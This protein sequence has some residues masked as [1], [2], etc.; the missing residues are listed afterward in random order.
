[1]CR[2]SRREFN[3][4]AITSGL[5]ATYSYAQP[6]PAAEQSSKLPL[7]ELSA[8]AKQRK[9][10]LRTTLRFYYN[11]PPSVS[12]FTP[13]EILHY[14]I[15][16]GVD[17]QVRTGDQQANAIGWLCWNYPAR[18]QRLF[19]RT[20]TGNGLVVN[21][22]PGVEGH[23]GQ[24]LALLAMS[25]VRRDFVIKVNGSEFA[26]NDLVEHEKLACD[27][28]TELTFQLLGLA[29]YLNAETVWQS[30]TGKEFT[31]ESLLKSELSQ[32]VNGAACGGSH[33]L[34]GISYALNRRNHREE[35]MTSVWLR[36]KKYIEDYIRYVLQLQN[37]D[38]SFSS[39]WFQSRGVT[40]DL[41][42]KLYT[43]GHVLEWLV[44]SVSNEQLL[45]DQVSSAVDYLSSTLHSQRHSG[46][47][48]GTVG[49]ALRALT[50]Y[51]ERVFGAKPGMRTELYGNSTMK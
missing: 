39:N 10:H 34:M 19:S 36:A 51:D 26:V 29:H 46:L 28:S 16:F 3:I 14:A 23:E 2:Y 8:A 9:K 31:I 1:M 11:N 20:A 12:Q 6:P 37:P 45:S 13:W 27:Y 4:A 21:S 35:P 38:G 41:P 32:Q 24:V 33:R 18:G 17:A 42:R 49:H 30:A 7:T 48:M 47:E 25:K 22:G 15:A 40:S 44:F 43:S 5:S 50:I